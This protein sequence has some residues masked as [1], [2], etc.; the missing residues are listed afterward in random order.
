MK[1]GDW[2]E[3]VRGG[4][5]IPKVVRVLEDKTARHA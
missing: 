4:D 3:I 1:I 2:I 5:V